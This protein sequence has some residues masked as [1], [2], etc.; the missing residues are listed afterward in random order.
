MN[1]RLLRPAGS[2]VVMVIAAITFAV[3]TAMLY[4]HVIVIPSPLARNTFTVYSPKIRSLFKKSKV[5]D[6]LLMALKMVI[7][8]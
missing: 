3:I 2:V 7:F 1:N 6:F 8:Y 4:V 5:D